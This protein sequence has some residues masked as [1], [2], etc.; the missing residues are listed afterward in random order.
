MEIMMMIESNKFLYY[1]AFIIGHFPG[2][3]IG[4]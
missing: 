2:I 3:P 1:I 4:G